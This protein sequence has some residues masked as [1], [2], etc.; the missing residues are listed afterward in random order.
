MLAG[1]TMAEG[2]AT[3][4]GSLLADAPGFYTPAEHVAL[5]YDRVRSIATCLADVR[6]HTR[7]WTI[8][9][10]RAFY[11]DEV[12]FGAGR[13]VS[14]TTRN[15][16]FPGSRVMYWTGMEQIV[17]LRARCGLDA[18]TFH[19]RLLSFGAA[20]ISFIADEETVWAQLALS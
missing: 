14:E 1:G 11:R 13:L 19:D 18:K 7:A 12:A 17:A 15:A 16:I 8:D 5:A 6:L 9:E 10:M 2:W 4:V 20:P 3:Y